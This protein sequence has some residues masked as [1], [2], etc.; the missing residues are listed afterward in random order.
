VQAA[1]LLRRV[2]NEFAHNIE[3]DQLEQVEE[4]LR[5]AMA[6]RVHELYGDQPPYST[7]AREMF[8]ALTFVALAG[9]QA[10]KSNLSILREKLEEGSL[11]GQLK[12]E[13]HKRFISGIE[14]TTGQSPLRI[15]ERAGWRATYYDKGIVSIEPTNPDGPP[16]TV[17]LSSLSCKPSDQE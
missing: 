9:F 16:V 1:D 15:E 7:S 3:R 8:K 14:A 6:Q 13:C 4:G 12:E 17:D 2:R 10:Y 5:A 11:V